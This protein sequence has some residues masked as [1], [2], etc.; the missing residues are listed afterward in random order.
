MTIENKCQSGDSARF[1][2]RAGRYR[3]S[4][5]IGIYYNRIAAEG[6]EKAPMIL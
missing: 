2:I 4:S 5:A 3:P 6:D 1:I